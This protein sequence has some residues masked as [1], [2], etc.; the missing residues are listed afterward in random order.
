MDNKMTTYEISTGEEY[1]RVAAGEVEIDT[2]INAIISSEE[3]WSYFMY[4]PWDY[5]SIYYTQGFFDGGSHCVTNTDNDEEFEIENTVENMT[6]EFWE[7]GYHNFNFSDDA[8]CKDQKL[9]E[10]YDFGTFFQCAKSLHE[11]EYG[12]FTL[13]LESELKPEGIYRVYSNGLLCEAFRKT[14][15]YRHDGSRYTDEE[16]YFDFDTNITE[17]DRESNL[18]LFVKTKNGLEEVSL[19]DLRSEVNKSVKDLK[20]KKAIK[21]FL[22]EKYI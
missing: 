13:E 4:S 12:P 21:K 1:G 20:D 22:S 7:D 3:S 16:D 15:G 8:F 17:S 19:E 9:T 11:G 5:D 18:F 14:S 10:K 6:G 2:I